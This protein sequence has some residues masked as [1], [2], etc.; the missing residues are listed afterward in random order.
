MAAWGIPQIS[1]G[2]I[3]RDN[4]L[5]GTELGKKAK[6]IMDRGELVPDDLVNEMVAERLSSPIPSN[7]YILDGFPRTLAQAEW[8]DSVS[9]G[10]SSG[11]LPVDCG[12]HQ[13]RLYSVIASYYR[14]AQLSNLQA[15]LQR[16][17]A[18]AESRRICDRGRYAVGRGAQT[19][20]K[21]F[22]RSGC[23][24]MRRKQLR[25]GTLSCLGRFVGSG[26]RTAG[27]RQYGSRSDG[28]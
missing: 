1:T 10:S 8:L 5:G 23:G 26:W 18:A 11:S 19:I 2:D 4:M 28:C 12:Q 24:L 6:A 16:L 13:G 22:L 3:L 25:C 21:R 17:L 9:G 27:G 20:R 15:H 7:G 14:P